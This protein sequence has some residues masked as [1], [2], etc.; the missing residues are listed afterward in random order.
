MRYLRPRWL[1]VYALVALLGAGGALALGRGRIAGALLADGHALVA[2]GQPLTALTDLT[3]A[4]WLTPA[5]PAGY[6]AR[7][8]AFRA[9][10][11]TAEA[12]ADLRAA[13][14]LAP[15]R[16]EPHALQGLLLL[17]PLE[18][19]REAIRAFDAALR[20]APGQA[21]VLLHRGRAYDQINNPH[22][23][24]K[25]F[26][27]AL[28]LQPGLAEA[29]VARAALHR[30]FRE[31]RREIAD[32]SAALRLRPGDVGLHEQRAEAHLALKQF[33]AARAD[34]D[35]VLA[36][37]PTAPGYFKRGTAQLNLGHYRAA[38]ADFTQVLERHRFSIAAYYNRA[39]A[40]A[41]LGEHDR[42]RADWAR[43]CELQTAGQSEACALAR[44][45]GANGANGTGG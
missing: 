41:A 16:A 22:R 18:R 23:A 31:R 39:R 8:R 4:I 17:E 24:V 3:L 15:E 25:D 13:S 40:Y 19:P 6:L 26:T 37:V 21:R 44:A 20:R 10:E 7:A 30:R 35:R 9:L 12:L 11:R 33:A 32:L 42:A 14:A 28:A 5:E 36:A 29:Y 34:L 2:Q 38:V 45:G 1:L 27:Q 43:V